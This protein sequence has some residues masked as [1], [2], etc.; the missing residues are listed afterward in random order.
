MEALSG[1][2][3]NVRAERGHSF[4][5]RGSC[6]V[7]AERSAPEETGRADPEKLADPDRE[8]TLL[9]LSIALIFGPL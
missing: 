6:R 2:F 3:I 4:Y 1:D 9:L 5:H 8:R 7:L